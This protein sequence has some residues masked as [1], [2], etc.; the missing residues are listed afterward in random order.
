LDLIADDFEGCCSAVN[1]CPC[2]LS[3]LLT[4][5]DHQFCYL[6]QALLW[7]IWKQ[8]EGIEEALY[9]KEF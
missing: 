5:I 2:K 1:N 8:L 7:Q 6:A 4:L 9:K 3:H